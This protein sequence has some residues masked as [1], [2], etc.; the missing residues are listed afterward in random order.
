MNANK[1][2]NVAPKPIATDLSFWSMHLIDTRKFEVLPVAPINFIAHYYSEKLLY[3]YRNQYRNYY[4]IIARNMKSSFWQF[5]GHGPLLAVDFI[6][7]CENGEFSKW[8][9]TQEHSWN[10]FVEFLNEI[11]VHPAWHADIQVS[12]SLPQTG[13]FFT[14][15][16]WQS[17][18]QGLTDWCWWMLMDFSLSAQPMKAYETIPAV[19]KIPAMTCHIV[20]NLALGLYRE[21]KSPPSR[22]PTPENTIANVPV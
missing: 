14:K 21:I 3:H 13:E 17:W 19:H 4:T 6:A 10:S 16:Q 15:S 7:P 18:L 1:W 11:S 8:E 9:F 2:I 20:K 22:T 12:W 5:T